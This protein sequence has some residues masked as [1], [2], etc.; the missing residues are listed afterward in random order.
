MD[1]STIVSICS[2]I[3]AFLLSFISVIIL[4]V[5]IRQNHLIL[6][7]DSRAY[8]SI[9]TDTTDCHA[10]TLYLILKN[11]GKS[12]AIITHF[13]CDTDLTPFSRLEGFVPFAHMENTSIA[14]GQ[15]YKYAL[16]QAPLKFSEKQE[17]NFN[18]SYKSN[19]K[20]YSE[21]ICVSLPPIWDEIHTNAPS[22][23]CAIKVIS[24][25]LQDINRRML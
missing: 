25:A 19:R 23:M 21:S 5:T 3:G 10:V 20:K 14:P 24:N 4:I 9:Y 15:S 22:E 7:N 17:I 1:I 18:V 16:S 8:L 12:N 6:E 2:S 11:F 13:E